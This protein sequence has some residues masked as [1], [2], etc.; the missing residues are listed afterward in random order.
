MNSTFAPGMDRA[1][2]AA[3]VSPAT[4]PPQ[5]KP[6]IGRR[7]ASSTKFD[8]VEQPGVETRHSDAGDGV[9]DHGCRCLATTSRRCATASV[10]T[11]SSSA[12]A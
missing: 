1:S 7:S 5:P 9:D 11:L 8:A 12:R 3:R 10:A 6:K 2:R 4:P